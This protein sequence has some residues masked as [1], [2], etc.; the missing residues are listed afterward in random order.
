MAA[1]LGGGHRCPKCGSDMVDRALGVQK[2]KRKTRRAA[3]KK[4]KKNKKSKTSK[5]G[6]SYRKNRKMSE[7]RRR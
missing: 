6:G 4:V 5:K 2:P 3:P 1:E 7:K